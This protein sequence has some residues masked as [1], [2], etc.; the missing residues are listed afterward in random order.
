MC[1]CGQLRFLR[2]WGPQHSFGCSLQRLRAVPTCTAPIVN[3]IYGH[4]SLTILYHHTSTTPLVTILYL[5]AKFQLQTY[6]N[7]WDISDDG[8]C[9]HCGIM[10]CPCRYQVKNRMGINLPPCL[11]AQFQ[12]QIYCNSGDIRS[13]FFHIWPCSDLDLD[14][15]PSK[16]PATTL[17]KV[18]TS[19]NLLF[20]RYCLTKKLYQQPLSQS[21]ST[22]RSNHPFAQFD[23]DQPQLFWRQV[24]L[25]SNN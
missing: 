8:C 15:Q 9:H 17:S 11:R 25:I 4:Q 3:C 14:P 21:D 12:R 1:Q 16:Q 13:Q 10:W 23:T 19:D 5:Q 24:I 18:S 2:H 6:C 7:Y 20:V 22:H